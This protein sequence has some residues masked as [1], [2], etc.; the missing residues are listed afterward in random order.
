[1]IERGRRALFPRYE[2]EERTFRLRLGRLV[3]RAGAAVF[4][5]WVGATIVLGLL[6][7]EPLVPILPVEIGAA[8]LVASVLIA[9]A[10][11]LTRG[12]LLWAGY[13]LSVAFLAY[14]AFRLLSDPA[15]LF[16]ASPILL[17]SV[18]VAG[19]TVS[20]A[21]GYLFAAASMAVNISAWSQA[22]RLPSDLPVPLTAETGIAFLIAQGITLFLT[23][24]LLHAFTGEAQS[25]IV[26]LNR[27]AAQMTELAHTDP[28]T[29]LANRRWLLELLEREFLRARRHRRPLSLIYL[30][31]DGFK[32][33]ND[34][35][36]HLFGDG[37]LRSAA[38][39]MQAVLRGSDLLARVGGDEFAVLLPETDLSGAEKVAAK[40]HRALAASTR[41]YGAELP[42]LSFSAGICQLQEDDR[43]IDDILVRADDAQYL[44]KAVGPGTIRTQAALETRPN[45]AGEKSV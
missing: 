6:G 29:G 28:L 4:I 11:L 13:L 12:R 33:V 10:L 14:P 31:L 35:F 45:L 16:F 20:P 34:R 38:R 7:Q 21:A 25:T 43:T 8:A 44:A 1:M 30:D 19:A 18:L 26:Q 32:L 23:A 9:A 17:I 37:I 15:H 41:P 3:V 40:F 2:G 24:F 36:G 42:P 39:S 5:A 27:Q 22:S